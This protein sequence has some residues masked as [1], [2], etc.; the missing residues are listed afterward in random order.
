MKSRIG[1]STKDAEGT[2]GEDE[3]ARGGGYEEV[4]LKREWV[5]KANM[6]QARL[7]NWCMW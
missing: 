7:Q 1:I 2:A 6:Y 3:K 5:A 4:D